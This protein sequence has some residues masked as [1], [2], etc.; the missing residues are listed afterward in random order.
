MRWT[1]FRLRCAL[2]AMCLHPLN[3]TAAGKQNLDVGLIEFVPLVT[4]TNQEPGGPI[5]EYA[6]DILRAADLP[7]K[8]HLLSI[9]RSLEQLRSHHIDLVLTL[10]KTK[11]REAYVRFSAQ[12]LLT[13]NSGFC[14]NGD[15]QKK[16]LDL[17]SRLAHVRGT[18][19]PPA[20]QKLELI[21]VTGENAQIRMLQMLIKGRVQAIYSPQPEIFIMAAHQAQIKI[22]LTCYEISK[23]RMPIYFGYSRDLPQHLLEKLENAFQKKLSAEDFDAFLKRRLVEAGIKPPLIHDIDVSYLLP[24]P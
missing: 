16:P 18:V 24:T 1:S 12:P 14:T 11:E 20:L 15:Y 2:A 13:F 8:F 19:I 22:S 10:F 17:T 9:N 6:Q 21:P 23:S 4:F 3:V 5:F 7:L